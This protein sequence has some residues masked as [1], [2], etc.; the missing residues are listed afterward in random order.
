MTGWSIRVGRTVGAPAAAVWPHLATPARYSVWAC[1]G[2]VA[3]FEPDRRMAFRRLT[4]GSVFGPAD[5]IDITLT[6]DG[7]ETTV[8]IDHSFDGLPD[9]HRRHAHEFYALGW[10][11]ALR[12]LAEQAGHG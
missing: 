4:P 11:E 7:G 8:M 10:T 12:V 2:T 9:E 5:L 6:A 1:P 3:A